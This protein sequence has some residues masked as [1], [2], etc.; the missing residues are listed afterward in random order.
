MAAV[1]LI[2]MATQRAE[3]HESAQIKLL[4]HVKGAKNEFQ[5]NWF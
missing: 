3:R 5:E 1:I 2:G 4:S